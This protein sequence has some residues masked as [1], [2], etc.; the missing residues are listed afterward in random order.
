VEV[1]LSIP[2]YIAALNASIHTPPIR[3]TGGGVKE[4]ESA[5]MGSEFIPCEP[6]KFLVKI[7]NDDGVYGFGFRYG[8]TLIT[9]VHVMRSMSSSDKQVY[10]EGPK[11]KIKLR[12]ETLTKRVPHR[13]V[14]FFVLPNEEWS[15]LGSTSCKI[16][17]PRENTGIRVYSPGNVTNSVNVSDGTMTKGDR[18]MLLAHT[19]STKKGSSGSPIVNSNMEV[20]G[21]H[22]LGGDTYNFG[23][24]LQVLKRP[25]KGGNK[26]EKESREADKRKM[27]EVRYDE[28]RAQEWAKIIEQKYGVQASADFMD[29]YQWYY[30]HLGEVS[31]D[32]AYSF[33]SDPEGYELTDSFFRDNRDWRDAIGE[34]T[35]RDD[36]EVGS[37]GTFKI[38]SIDQMVARLRK[39][40]VDQDK[41]P[42]I[43]DESTR[44]HLEHIEDLEI[45]NRNQADIIE[46]MVADH[47]KQQSESN[48][49][50][51]RLMDLLK[52]KREDEE[53]RLAEVQ[54][55][56]DE[57]M[58]E[59]KALDEEA[60]AQEKAYKAA[61][62]AAK[63]K[64][65]EV[66]KYVTEN[67]KKVKFN[68]PEKRAL[69][70]SPELH[71][72]LSVGVAQVLLSNKA[73][74]DLNVMMDAA[75]TDLKDSGSTLESAP[76]TNT[77]PETRESTV[78]EPLRSSETES[79]ASAQPE[80]N[81]IAQPKSK[82]KKR[83]KGSKGQSGSTPN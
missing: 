78:G 70:P 55:K 72:E 45:K 7:R 59:V 69:V 80:A 21:I 32:D 11:G 56:R 31:E 33:F 22:L 66:A 79:S 17:N 15:A 74:S 81:Q 8:S 46:R 2:A 67:G 39:R 64:R 60:K 6:P 49:E 10:L 48:A 40:V 29:D 26:K 14:M 47:R 75:S 62:A 82:P 73:K 4:P 20:V 57:M 5:K 53:K 13:D 24:S 36:E 44:R 52:L 3:T 58:A 16:T 61:Q 68:D 43:V 30:D 1:E 9:A 50:R 37:I 76:V 25:L 41:I 51:Q 42:R 35:Y 19:A 71:A 54:A 27:W 28:E 63:R 38:D 83:G 65:E 34:A 77:T 23:M 12:S 18:F